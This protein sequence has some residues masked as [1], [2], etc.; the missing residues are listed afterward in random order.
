MFM[1]FALAKILRAEKFLR[2]NDL[3]A[4][5]R[6]A[7][8]ERKRFLQVRGGIC[9]ATRLQQSQFYGLGSGAFHFLGSCD[10]SRAVSS[11]STVLPCESSIVEAGGTSCPNSSRM[12]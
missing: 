9:R 11:S 5:F 4:I 2:A 12:N 1:V 6:G 3:R 7:F 10:L 8:D